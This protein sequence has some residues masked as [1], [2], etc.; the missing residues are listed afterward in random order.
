MHDLGIKNQS[1]RHIRLE[2]EFGDGY[3]RM[4]D[5]VSRLRDGLPTIWTYDYFNGDISDWDTSQ[6]TNMY[7]MFRGVYIV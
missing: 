6:V 1:R 7:Q 4:G 5:N 2:H 3:E